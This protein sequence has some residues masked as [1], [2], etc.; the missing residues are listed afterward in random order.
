MGGIAIIESGGT[1]GVVVA[2]RTYFGWEYRD[3]L[4]WITVQCQEWRERCPGIPFYGRLL[5]KGR[6]YFGQ[7]AHRTFML[8]RDRFVRQSC[9]PYRTSILGY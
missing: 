9:I 3:T 4:K 5:G 1:G 6:H 2:E 7:R 8:Y